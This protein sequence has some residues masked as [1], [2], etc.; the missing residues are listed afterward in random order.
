M[1]KIMPT[2]LAMIAAALALLALSPVFAQV[3]AVKVAGQTIRYV[4]VQTVDMKTEV[5]SLNRS[6][7]P[8]ESVPEELYITFTR[9]GC[10]T[11][12]EKGLSKSYPV[13]DVKLIGSPNNMSY[14]CV[15][16]G[17]ASASYTFTGHI[18]SSSFEY[19]N[20]LT[21]STDYKRMNF[22]G[23]QIG[24]RYRD[25]VAYQNVYVY[26]QSVPPVP[27]QQTGPTGPDRMW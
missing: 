23:S 9:N 10:Y 4:Y 24:V 14:E 12:D 20:I 21:F 25:E 7:N 26:E 2:K 27:Q 8:N 22:N 5:R 18:N 13:I 3:S 6:F 17:T 11:S 1:K 15:Q 16:G 19:T